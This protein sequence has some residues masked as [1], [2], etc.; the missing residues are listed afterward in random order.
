MAKRIGAGNSHIGRTIDSSVFTD[1][2]GESI[3]D[4]LPRHHQDADVFVVL[5][6]NAGRGRYVESASFDMGCAL[7]TIE[8]AEQRNTYKIAQGTASE[9][10]SG[11][12]R[13]SLGPIALKE[14]EVWKVY[15]ELRRELSD[16]E[17][18]EMLDK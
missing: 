12:V 2:A 14:V 11:L 18:S 16:A 6:Y 5:G 8:T 15:T 17:S 3:R 10:D 9:V 4:V 1:T 7:R 13:G